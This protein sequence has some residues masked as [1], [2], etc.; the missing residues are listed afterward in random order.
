[1]LGFTPTLGQSGVATTLAALWQQS[2]AQQNDEQ[3]DSLENPIP[4]ITVK[5]AHTCALGTR[6]K[7]V[8]IQK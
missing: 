4:H 3:T 2:E 7:L 1:V 5:Y 8:T 6:F